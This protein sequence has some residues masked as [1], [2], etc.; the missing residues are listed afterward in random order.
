MV[1]VTP[2]VVSF[3]FVFAGVFVLVGLFVHPYL[4]PYPSVPVTVFELR[5][6]VDNWSGALLGVGLGALSARQ[7]S[8]RTVRKRAEEGERATPSN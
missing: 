3:L 2:A 6:W 8:R 7:T 1:A 4:P 5:Y